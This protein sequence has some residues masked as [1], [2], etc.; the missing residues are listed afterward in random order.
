MNSDELRT[1][2][3]ALETA[4]QFDVVAARELVEDFELAGWVYNAGAL[5]RRIRQYEAQRELEPAATTYYTDK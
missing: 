5:R 3:I 1:R 2:R 4:P